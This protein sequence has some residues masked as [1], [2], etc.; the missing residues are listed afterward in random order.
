MILSCFLR[1]RAPNPEILNCIG[2]DRIP[3]L[4]T[5]AKAILTCR[6]VTR[7]HTICYGAAS[8][9]FGILHVSAIRI[10][11]KHTSKAHV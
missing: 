10:V 5:C 1:V 7:M 3:G 11:T 2:V 6:N 8:L 4:S 9:L